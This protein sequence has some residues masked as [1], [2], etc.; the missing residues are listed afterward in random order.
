MSTRLAVMANGRVEQIGTPAEVY[1]HP[2]SEF[3]AGFVGTSN[4]IERHGGRYTIRPEKIH[5]LAVGEEAPEDVDSEAGVIREV[6][7][8]GAVTRF[9]VEL[10]DGTVITAL[11]QNLQDTAQEALAQR[12]RRVRLAWRPDHLAPVSTGD[13]SNEEN[14]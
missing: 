1:E 12:G 9:V 7:Y 6:S 10:E 3:V 4:I 14:S 11:R 2:A 13:Q 8:L 5:M